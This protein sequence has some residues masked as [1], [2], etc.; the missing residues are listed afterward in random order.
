M[1]ATDHKIL[2]IIPAYNESGRIGKVVSEVRSVLPSAKVV[3]IDDCSSDATAAEAVAAGASVLPHVVNLGY[4]AALETGYLYAVRNGFDVVCQMDADGQHL[5]SELPVILA[6]V[7]AGDAD[8]V[9]GSRYLGEGVGYRTPAL[10][11][12]GQR[13]FGGII[14]RLSGLAITDPTSGF[15]CL[16]RRAVGFLASGVFPTDFPDANVLLMLHYA[17][18]RIAEVSAKMVARS[19]GVSMHSGL[20]PVYY[21]MKMLLSIF[22]VVLNVRK[23]RRYAGV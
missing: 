16:G 2:A 23:W 18:L 15:Q 7:L 13:F 6:P 12:A 22:L 14:N 20:K 8:L 9:L 19:E 3:V 4:G 17:R 21:V 1:P 11:R 5:A 10:R